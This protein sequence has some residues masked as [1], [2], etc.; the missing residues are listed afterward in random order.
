MEQRIT[1][2]SGGQP[3]PEGLQRE[4]EA[5][6]KADFSQVRVHNSAEDQTDAGRLSAKAFTHGEHIW[7]ATGQSIDDRR[8][9][10]HELTHVAQ[11][12]GAMVDDDAGS[13]ITRSAVEVQRDATDQD[14]TP[15]YAQGLTDEALVAQ[16]QQVETLLSRQSSASGAERESLSNNLSLLRAQIETRRR[17]FTSPTQTA[18]VASTSGGRG[19]T[20]ATSIP[21]G[22]EPVGR[23]GLINRDR[24]P[25]VR[26]RSSPDTNAD[27]IL[28][29][30]PFSTT[31]QVIKRFPG[32]WFFVS[33]TTGDLGYVASMYVSIDLPEPNARLHRVA[34]GVSGT[35]IAIAE[36][37]YGQYSDDWGQ[38]LRFYV[39]VLAWAN[40][41]SVPNTTGGWEQVHFQADSLI[42]IPSYRFARSLRGVVNSG[43]L[44]YNVADAL[45]VATVIERVSELWDDFRTALSLS[46]NYMGEA[47]ARHVEKALYEALVSLAVMLVAAIAIVAI[48]TAIGAALGF[49]FGGGVGAAPGAAAGF[50]VGMIILEWLGLAMLLVWIGQAIAETAAAFGRFLGTVWSA[51]GDE[52]ILDRAAREFAEGIGILIGNLLQ[53]IVMYAM[54]KGLTSAL[55]IF[56]NSKVGRSVGETRAGEWLSE[57]LRSVQAGEAPIPGP[58]QVLNYFRGVEIVDATNNPIGEFDGVDLRTG[59]L[60]ENKAAGGLERINPRTGRPQQTPAAWARRQIFEKTSTRIQNLARAAATRPT[61]TGSGSVPTL[62]EIQGIRRLHF[63]IDGDA[64]ALRAAVF[65]EIANLSAQ[66][67][68]WTFTAEFGVSISVP[69]VPDFGEEEDPASARSTST[70]PAESPPPGE[71]NVCLPEEPPNASFSN[72]ERN[73]CQ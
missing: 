28:R 62:A 13:E 32:D 70:T 1:S 57:R 5:G 56:R 27:N 68:D 46:T 10:A 45:G 53:A 9:M 22:G 65:A 30:L 8:L 66:F 35:A 50:E 11:Q 19:R 29:T 15:A 17:A 40:H 63:M 12:G 59:R 43:S 61:A 39:N 73:V 67:P 49:V 58:R 36:R 48:S 21:E 37:Y 26:L 7:L 24:E 69:P 71:A 31:V 20:A 4:M 51:R 52:R 60:V 55:G 23:V 14:I 34:S 54:S 33:T 6:L 72:A 64:P 42:W 3:L 38:D 16:L 2:A 44:S 18:A 41:I 25:E 47:I